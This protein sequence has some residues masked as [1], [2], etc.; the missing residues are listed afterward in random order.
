M[1][2]I[3]ILVIACVGAL[4][5]AGVVAAFALAP[6]PVISASTST[7]TK[8]TDLP[9]TLPTNLDTANPTAT[10]AAPG[11]QFTV[12][13]TLGDIPTWITPI[14]ELSR[15]HSIHVW[16]A[17]AKCMQK[18]G[19]T[20]F[21]YRVYWVP[22]AITRDSE[23]FWTTGMT[24]TKADKALTDEFGPSHSSGSS[25]GCNGRAWVALEHQFLDGH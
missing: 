15:A 11:T 2:K 3:V 16:L 24:S 1:R 10:P 9:S 22:A 7:S 6:K 4:C 25:T 19:Y 14:Y 21:H 18:L 17:T 13:A 23:N 5:L 8:S 12:D 20:D